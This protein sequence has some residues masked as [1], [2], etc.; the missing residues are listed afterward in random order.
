MV[1]A[2]KKDNIFMGLIPNMMTI[3]MRNI[4]PKF[5]GLEINDNVSIPYIVLVLDQFL[6]NHGHV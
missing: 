4:E 2:I 5:L 3:Y 1:K 6:E